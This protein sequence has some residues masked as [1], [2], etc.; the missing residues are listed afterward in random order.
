MI[1]AC[2]CCW[3]APLAAILAA[4]GAAKASDLAGPKGAVTAF[5][6]PRPDDARQPRVT[7]DL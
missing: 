3:Q 5:G 4:S 1:M 7:P 6:V 2:C